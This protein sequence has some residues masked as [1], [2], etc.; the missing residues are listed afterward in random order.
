MFLLNSC[1]KSNFNFD[2]KILNGYFVTSIAFDKQGVAWIGTFDQGLI[3]YNGGK[4]TVY[5][6]SNSVIQSYHK[7]DDIAVDSK[8][9]I[10]I[11]GSALVKYDG[12]TFTSFHSQNSPIPEDWISSIVIDSKDNIWFTSCR[13]KQGGIVKFDGDNWEVY[14]PD[15]SPMPVNYVKSIAIDKIDN[16]YLAFQEKVNHVALAKISNG[17][18]TFITDSILGFHPYWF[19]DIKVDSKGDLYGSMD[20]SLSSLIQAG[21]PQIF[22]FDGE[23][24]HQL[25]YDDFSNV[26]SLTIDSEDHIWCIDYFGYAVYNGSSWK[27]DH[28][29]FK[30]SGVFAIEESPDGKMWIGTGTGI[31]ISN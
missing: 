15:N 24:S 16:V 11:G 10:W 31:Y 8:N 14:T 26:Q 9:N 28:D 7:I 3:E 21:R 27:I 17:N 6:S 23:T 1:E 12:K 30:G 13:Y 5:N 25:N 29:S 22:T 4:I 18:W 19:G 20:Y 2:K